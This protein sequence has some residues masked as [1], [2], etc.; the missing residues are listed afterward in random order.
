MLFRPVGMEG[1]YDELMPELADFGDQS[2]LVSLALRC[3]G[4]GRGY[5]GCHGRSAGCPAIFA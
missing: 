4:R 2:G 1:S 5:D 3:G